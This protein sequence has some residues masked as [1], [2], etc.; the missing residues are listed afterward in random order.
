MT[1]SLAVAEEGVGL[2]GFMAAGCGL[3][4]FMAAG[5][6]PPTSGA[7]LMCPA[8]SQ[9]VQVVGQSRGAQV[10]VAQVTVTPVGTVLGEA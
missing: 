3:G 5:L 8:P 6:A 1:R 2:G 10:T 4:V 9:A 7:A